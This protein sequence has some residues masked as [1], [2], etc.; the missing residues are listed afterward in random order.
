MKTIFPVF[1]SCPTTDHFLARQTKFQSAL[2][3]ICRFGCK[4]FSLDKKF[5]ISRPVIRFFE[6]FFTDF[7]DFA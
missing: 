7:F 3:I 4:I 1:M 5:F 6:K 2:E